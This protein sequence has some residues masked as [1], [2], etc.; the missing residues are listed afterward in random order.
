MR[1]E[2]ELLMS[3]AMSH[4]L[5]KNPLPVSGE[6][7]M[8]A[9][10]HRKLN[11]NPGGTALNKERYVLF[12]IEQ[13]WPVPLARH[14]LV[15]SAFPVINNSAVPSRPLGVAYAQPQSARG[16]SASVGSVTVFERDGLSCQA[17]KIEAP[18]SEYEAI[19]TNIAATALGELH[20][21]GDVYIPEPI[22]MVCT[23]ANRDDCCGLYGDE[24]CDQLE[25]AGINY[26]RV[27]HIGGH[28][29][30]PTLVS[31]PYGRTWAEADL[32]LAKRVSQNTIS[33]EDLLN[34]C[35]GWWGAEAGK[36]QVAEIFVRSQIG[37]DF[38]EAPHITLEGSIATVESGINSWQVEVAFLAE[39]PTPN[40]MVDGGLPVKNS[41][42]YKAKFK[43][44]TTGSEAA[45]GAQHSREGQTA[46]SFELSDVDCRILGAMIEKSA[47]T[48]DIY[49][50]STNSIKTA[51]NQKTSRDPVV[52]YDDRTVDAALKSMRERGLARR[53]STPGS[54]VH[55]HRHCL[56]EK[57]G[58]G[59]AELA[60]LAVLM[61][62]GAQTAGELRARTQ[63]I[64]EFSS[65]EATYERL[66]V[67]SRGDKPLVKQLPRVAGQKEQ[68]WVHLLSQDRYASSPANSQPSAQTHRDTAPAH[69]SQMRPG[70]SAAGVLGVSSAPDREAA[71]GE[72]SK[73]DE[74]L[75]G[76]IEALQQQIAELAAVYQ[77]LV[78]RIEALELDVDTS[79]APPSRPLSE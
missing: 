60:L 10:Y 51:C 14:E 23:H 56:D 5:A 65:S 8:C 22:L 69:T 52:T 27:S 74:Q 37:E 40:C 17:L 6:S 33:A 66:E 49:P 53:V 38:A 61:L 45:R 75:L 24:L 9:D 13:P 67:L 21:L 1:A 76:R 43:P 64:F 31:M 16:D 12:E 70:Q 78:G 44:G 59:Q 2:V 26:C 35:R 42:A 71:V 30:A 58:I 4:L 68:R 79:D 18:Q 15:G 7:V 47:T 3:N 50:M 72:R 25:K 20:Q 55:K 32:E 73:S 57:L 19:A 34:N 48:P 46:R 77:D 41:R 63:R 39:V 36:A 62:R 11:I 54:R 28:K 29:Y